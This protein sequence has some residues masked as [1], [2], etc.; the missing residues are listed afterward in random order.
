VPNRIVRDA[1]LD[2][3]RYHGLSSD[4]ARLLFFELLLL[5]D[6]YGLTP[7]Y[8]LFLSRRTAAAR[9]ATDVGADVNPPLFAGEVADLHVGA[10]LRSNGRCPTASGPAHRP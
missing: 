1:I 2:S 8:P 9:R 5:A 10:D 4:T 6:D 7:A 3:P